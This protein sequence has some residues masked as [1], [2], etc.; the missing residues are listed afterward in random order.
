MER[1]YPS[2]M[3]DPNIKVEK[4]ATVIEILSLLHPDAKKNSLRR[5]VDHG[6]V[7]VNGEKVNRAN[8]KISVGV[9]LTVLSK[10][11][12]DEKLENPSN[13]IPNPEII[14]SDN[15]V[16]IVDKPA[17]LLSVATDRGESDT[18]YDRTAK[19]ASENLKSPIHLVH[20]LDRETSGCLIFA[21]SLEIRDML[22]KQFK[23]RSIERIYYAVVFGKPT[24]SSG[25][26][27]TRIQET[28]DKRV[29]LVIGNKRAGKE[30]ITNWML[31][32]AGSVHSLIRI[33]IGRRAQIRLHMTNLGCPVLGDTRY[34]RGKTSVNR[35][36]LH[37]TELTFNHPNGKKIHVKSEIPAKLISELNRKK[38]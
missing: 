19:W 38:L 37:A 12:G 5:M 2:F 24:T 8:T 33:K 31:E 36:C 4:E 26:E 28:K 20:R 32:K 7:M 23:N 17:G 10:S 30:A 15:S 35:L 18:M 34:G 29:R 14:Y 9:I 21:T 3:V 16:I 1:R 6:R 11:E 25:I 22:Q 27:T 13:L